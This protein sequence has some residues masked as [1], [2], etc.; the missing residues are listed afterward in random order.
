MTRPLLPA[1]PRSRAPD[2]HK[3]DCGSVLVVAGSRSYPGAAILT[4]LGAGRAGAGYVHLAV[5]DAIVGEVLPA[6]PFAVVV[7]GTADGRQASIDDA[8]A[9]LDAAG[10]C[11]A[12][13]LGPGLGDHA[14]TD[15][16]VARLVAAVEAPLVLD[17]DGLNAVARTGTRVLAERAGPT[18]V[19]PHPGEFARLADLDRTPRDDEGRRHAAE[20]LARRLGVVVVLKGRHTV[21]TDGERTYVE[22]AGNP[23][24]ATGGTGDVLAGATGALLA[25][26]DADPAATAALA[27]AV[28]ARAG[29]LAAERLGERGVLPIDVAECIGRAIEERHRI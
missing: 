1:R 4:A 23:G 21:V 8:A 5:P 11:D 15:A 6:V 10:G 19:T 17:A 7:R 18:V 13:V 12:V 9:L 16:L 25:D 3:G 20:D 2:A 14:E 22:A 24:L 27:V 26:D 28:H 29:D